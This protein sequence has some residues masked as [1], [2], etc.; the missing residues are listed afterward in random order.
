M[1]HPSR[2]AKKNYTISTFTNSPYSNRG[3]TEEVQRIYCCLNHFHCYG[4]LST[5][6][7][8]CITKDSSEQAVDVD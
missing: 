3:I 6:Q 7:M 5:T 2:K 8:A 1:N 4:Q